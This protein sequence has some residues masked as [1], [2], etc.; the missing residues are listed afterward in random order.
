MECALCLTV[1]PFGVACVACGTQFGRY[2]CT[3]CRFFDDD[4]RKQQFHC[5]K[6]GICR[7]GGRDSF[8]HCDTCGCCYSNA[9]AHSHTCVERSTHSNCPVCLQFLFE[10]IRPVSVLG[11]GHTIHEHCFL[12]LFAHHQFTCPTC[13]RSMCDMSGVWARRDA[14]IAA[15]PMP[16]EYARVRVKIVCSDC[17][18]LAEV[19]WNVLGMKCPVSDCGSYNTRRI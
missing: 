9:I 14:E 19:P 18:A 17:S 7:V 4:C 2:A 13:S 12:S 15:T 5:E 16:D 10:S 3:L 8:S 6:C 1:Q 11:C